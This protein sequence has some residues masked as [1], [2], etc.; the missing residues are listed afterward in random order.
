MAAAP[1][2]TPLIDHQEVAMLREITGHSGHQPSQRT[3]SLP[4]DTLNVLSVLLLVNKKN[5][6]L[7]AQHHAFC[8][9]HGKK[10]QKKNNTQTNKQTNKQ[11]CLAFQKQTV[12]L[13][14]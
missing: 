7:P 8:D 11:T 2:T 3:L 10:K 13:N 14:L 9:S 12:A 1:S 5:K 6:Q 4:L